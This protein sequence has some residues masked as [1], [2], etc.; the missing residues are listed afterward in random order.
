MG[1][2]FSLSVLLGIS[3]IRELIYKWHICNGLNMF[4]TGSGTIR[5]CGLVGV[6]VVLLE[7]VYQCGGGQWDPPPSSPWVSLLLAIFWSRCRALSSF[8]STMSV[9]MLPCCIILTM[10]IMDCLPAPIK[11]YPLKE[12]PWSWCLFTAMETKAISHKATI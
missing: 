8:S 10:M 11:C 12:L 2:A 7:G 3:R 5:R 6:C 9:W 4:G 1:A